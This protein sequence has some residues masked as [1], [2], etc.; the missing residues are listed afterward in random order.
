MMFSLLAAL[1]AY[2]HLGFLTVLVSFYIDFGFVLLLTC[3]ILNW[4][5]IFHK[6]INIFLLHTLLKCP[7]HGVVSITIYQAGTIWNLGLSC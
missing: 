4:N 1:A 6:L 2:E 3:F 7:L 5:F